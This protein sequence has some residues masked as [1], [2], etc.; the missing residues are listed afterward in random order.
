MKASQASRWASSELK[1]CSKPSSLLLRV[2]IAQ[3][4]RFWPRPVTL[5]TCLAIGLR[6]PANF[7]VGDEFG[8]NPR[9]FTAIQSE[10]TRTG[11]VRAGDRLRNLAERGI[12]FSGIFEAVLGDDDHVCP[13]APFPHKPRSGT[14]G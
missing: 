5:E 9:C 4:R 1:S 12:G 14:D 13:S 10:E 3:R 6:L 2:S 11:P 7:V 8:L